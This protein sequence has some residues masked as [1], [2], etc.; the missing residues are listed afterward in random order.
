SESSVLFPWL[1][2]LLLLLLILPSVFVRVCPWLMLLLL[3]GLPSWLIFCFAYANHATL[4]NI[5]KNK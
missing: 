2:L 5:Y 3:L 1:M 4:R